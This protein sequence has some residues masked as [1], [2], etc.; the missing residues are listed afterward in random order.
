MDFEEK[1][2]AVYIVASR[3]RG[4]IY[5]GVTSKLYDRISAHKAK[6]FAGFSAEYN[7]HQLVWYEHHHE[8]LSAI[9]RETRIKNWRRSWKIQL[10]ENSNRDWLDLHELIEDRFYDHQ[11]RVSKS[12]TPLALR[13][14]LE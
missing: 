8:M 12:L 10:I 13:A 6:T 5:I 7:C 4:T 2:P 14:R 9:Q 1:Q 3:Y 11:K